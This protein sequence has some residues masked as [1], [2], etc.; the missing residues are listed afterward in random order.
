MHIIDAHI[1]LYDNNI[2]PHSHLNTINPLFSQLLGDYSKLPR[3]YLF[4]DYTQ[5]INHSVAGIVWHEFVSDQPNEEI[6]WAANCLKSIN[7]PHAMVAKIDFSDPDFDQTLDFLN[8]YPRV[9]AIRQHMAYHHTDP[10]KR[11]TNQPLYFDSPIWHNNLKKLSR[12]PYKCGLEIFSNQLEDMIKVI[13][14]HSTI[15]FTIALMG[16]PHSITPECFAEWTTQLKELKALD[17]ICF[18]FSALECI[19]GIDWSSFTVK[20]WFDAAISILGI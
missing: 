20:P 4:D 16:W 11:F 1:H 7:I 12:L 17:N 9:S 6:D 14:Q 3:K 19:F 13:K 15:E 2:V 18:Q 10:L 5:S 8:Q